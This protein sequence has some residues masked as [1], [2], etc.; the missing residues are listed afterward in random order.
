MGGIQLVILAAGMGSRFGG[1]KQSEPIDG[2]GCFIIDYSIY[3]ALQAGIDDI[4]IVI[5]KE[6]E[7]DFRGIL[8][9]RIEKSANI[10]YAFQ[11]MTGVPEGFS[12]PPGREKP[13]GT[14]HAVL[15]ARGLVNRPF[16]V[17]NADD[18][19]GRDAYTEMARVSAGL[20]AGEC[21]LAGYTLG[22]TLSETGGV[23]RAVCD[24]DGSGNLSHIEEHSGLERSGGAVRGLNGSGEQ[25]ILSPDMTVSL[26]FWCFHN[27]VFEAI[28]AGFAGFLQK[29]LKESSLKA[30]YYIP[31]FVQE[32]INLG[33]LKA[34][35]VPVSARWHGITY[36]E[37]LE[38]LKNAVTEYKRQGIYPERLWNNEE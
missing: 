6:M 23:S 31:S 8:G 4:V 27:T 11:E 16:T 18:F 9:K 37:D 33:E 32:Q 25:V 5:K 24:I 17:I 3:D 2:E 7:H 15:S 10:T 36:R 13:W 26:N 21:A 12:V 35:V 34:S 14:A 20:K 22:N 38:S 30:E 29:T 28:G 1:M 19:Y